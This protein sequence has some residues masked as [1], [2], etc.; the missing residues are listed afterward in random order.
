M[1]QETIRFSETVVNEV[2]DL[3]AEGVFETKSEFYRFASE[4]LLDAINDE[5]D[6]EMVNYDKLSGGVRERIDSAIG[7]Q[8]ALPDPTT[9]PNDAGTFYRSALVVRRHARK[10]EIEQAEEHI[11]SHYPPERGEYLMLEDI[12]HHCKNE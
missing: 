7:E 2:E 10:G 6:P 11:D 3:V 5:Y 8:D 4:M 9:Q 12:L 1:V